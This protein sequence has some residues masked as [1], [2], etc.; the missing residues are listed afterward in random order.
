V[1]APRGTLFHHYETDDRGLL[2]KINLIVATQ[3]NAAPIS[4]SV[5]K[6][7]REFIQGGVVRE[8]LLNRVEMAF[9]AYDPCL[10]CATHSLP[11]QMPMIVNIRNSGGCV[12]QTLR[13]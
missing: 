3:N 10:S 1:E 13:R 6:A 7:A 5:K 8:G 4:L 11:G 9:R 2:T 12:I